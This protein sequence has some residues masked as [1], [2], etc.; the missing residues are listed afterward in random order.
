LTGLSSAASFMDANECETIIAAARETTGL[1]RREIVA[2]LNA[3]AAEFAEAARRRF[4]GK[5]EW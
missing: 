2:R 4:L 1:S 5:G 3:A